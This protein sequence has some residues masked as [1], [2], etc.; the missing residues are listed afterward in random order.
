MDEGPRKDITRLLRAIDDGQADAS[1]NLLQVVYNQLYAIAEVQLLDQVPWHTLGPTALVNEAFI[2]MFGRTEP[3]WEN[4]RH[5]FWAAGR[6]MKDILVKHA[7]QHMAAK[8]NNGKHT[9][10]LED[11]DAVYE[12]SEELLAL[13]EA[14]TE[15]ALVHPD[16][17]RLVMLRFFAGL[18]AKRAAELMGISEATL[19]RQWRFARAWLKGRVKGIRFDEKKLLN[20]DSD[21]EV[22]AAD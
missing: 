7:R 17:E 11:N 9:L 1:K 21:P 12:M 3:S 22:S 15:L 19:W 14:L 2:K 4:R 16:H 18:D 10:S 13:D 20:H 5:F 6:A 8:R